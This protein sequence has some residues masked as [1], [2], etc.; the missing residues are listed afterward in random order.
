MNRIIFLFSPS[1][2]N[3]R[4]N[5]LGSSRTFLVILWETGCEYFF[6]LNKSLSLVMDRLQSSHSTADT[7]LGKR[8][9]SI[10]HF[11]QMLT[12]SLLRGH[13]ALTNVDYS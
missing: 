13:V 11:D 5:F 1:S 9:R 6:D 7:P 8:K 4:D 3:F 2:K 12:T 10:G